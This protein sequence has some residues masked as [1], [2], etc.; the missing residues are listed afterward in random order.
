MQR[1]QSGAP[2]HTHGSSHMMMTVAKAG[3]FCISQYEERVSREGSRVMINTHAGWAA[4]IGVSRLETYKPL[5]RGWI[6]LISSIELIAYL[7]YR[8]NVLSS[9]IT[10]RKHCTH[11]GWQLT[12]PC[13]NVLLLGE[14]C[15]AMDHSF[16]L[17][18]LACP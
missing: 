9:P 3:A 12:Q 6:A 1:L 5:L 14:Q 17:C 16:R 15:L 8:D 11:G 13:V 7:T 2:S 10:G 18:T 4:V